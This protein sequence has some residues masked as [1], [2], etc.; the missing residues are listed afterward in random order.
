V[1]TKVDID[2]APIEHIGMFCAWVLCGVSLLGPFLL[3]LVELCFR[4][5]KPTKP[6]TRLQSFCGVETDQ[7]A[8]VMIILI[9]LWVGVIGLG[10]AAIVLA[11]IVQI[12]KNLF[13]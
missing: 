8:I 12:V 7:G 13:H 11:L 10:P 6:R 2:I 3:A 5:R 4:K 9:Y 1:V